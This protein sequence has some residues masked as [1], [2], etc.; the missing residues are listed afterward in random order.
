M[1]KIALSF[2]RPMGMAFVLFVLLNSFLFLFQSGKD[3]IKVSA[4]NLT[5]TQPTAGGHYNLIPIDFN[6]S[7]PLLA[8]SLQLLLTPSGGGTTINIAFNMPSNPY[9]GVINPFNV[10]SSNGVVGT[11]SSTIPDGVYTFIVRW[12]RGSD[13]VVEE[14]N[15]SNV[16]IDTVTSTGS[17]NAPI[18]GAYLDSMPI[19]VAL[20]EPAA[21]GSVYITFTNTTYGGFVRINLV[22]NPSGTF[23]INPR[24]IAVAYPITSVTS[25][26]MPSGRYNATLV[27]QDNYGNPIS[28]ITKTDIDFLT[29]P[30]ITIN[31]PTKNSS[32]AI[33]NTTI[34]VV[35]DHDIGATGV[36]IGGGTTVGYSNY[37]CVQTT[38]AQV[39]C[40]I[41]INSSG[42]LVIH[43]T[44]GGGLVSSKTEANYAI[45][46]TNP[47][48]PSPNPTNPD[49][50][51]PAVATV[52]DEAG[53]VVSTPVTNADGTP[54]GN[55]VV[56]SPL[57]SQ[58]S[59]L[60]LLA[61]CLFAFLVLGLLIAYLAYQHPKVRAWL[62]DLKAKLK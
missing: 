50:V 48:A 17:F 53:N 13:N 51:T 27:Y 54:I 34:R 25:N 28:S 16:T 23:F 40:T 42:N 19:D 47:T 49:E 37:N 20:G 56:S 7:A 8:G 36:Q 33:T 39:D 31:A 32:S 60:G 57:K 4:A 24:N 5:V 22:D 45:S 52:V 44:S 9:S 61:M 59:L 62:K 18:S 29:E 41:A 11:N 30:V 35:S 55:N 46:G 14:V 12:Q 21:P 10:S 58:I 15:L 26:S 2:Y 6:E 1:K 3:L 43:A 38:W